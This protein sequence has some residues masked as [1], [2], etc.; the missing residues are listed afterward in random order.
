M[1]DYIVIQI[2]KTS[3]EKGYYSIWSFCEFLV[4]KSL[5]QSEAL[6]LGLAKSTY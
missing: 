5:L 3:L 6:L 1:L 2:R 4:Y